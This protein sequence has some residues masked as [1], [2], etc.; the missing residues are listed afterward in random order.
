MHLSSKMTFSAKK[1]KLMKI[2]LLHCKK[3]VHFIRKKHFMYLSFALKI[4]FRQLFLTEKDVFE[5]L[6]PR[7]L[8]ICLVALNTEL[9]FLEAL[10]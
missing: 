2:C 8:T 3:T 9:V 7:I 5:H 4:L 6:W 1:L 10:K